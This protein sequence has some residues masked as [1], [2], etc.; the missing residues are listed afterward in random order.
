MDDTK[1]CP[2]CA[3]TIKAAA[4]VCRFCYADLKLRDRAIVIPAPYV[5]LWKV[6]LVFGIAVAGG[7]LAFWLVDH[8]LG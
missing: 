3:E 6:L 5:R 1:T 2:Y 4:V 7:V 8:V